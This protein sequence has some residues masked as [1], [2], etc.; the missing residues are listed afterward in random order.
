MLEGVRR[1]LGRM[2]AIESR[3]DGFRRLGNRE[4]SITSSNFRENLIK[5]SDEL[6]SREKAQMSVTSEN[7][8]ALTSDLSA[9]QSSL[10]AASALS[11]R[12][13]SL[14]PQI[15]ESSLVSGTLASV[16]EDSGDPAAESEEE[17]VGLSAQAL[18][19]MA[20]PRLA[21]MEPQGGLS[22]DKIRAMAGKYASEKGL[23]PELVMSVIEAESSYRPNEVSGAGAMGLMQLMPG[24]AE[25][26]GV[27]DAF[28]PEENIKGGTEYLSRMMKRFG[29][30]ELALA[31]YN[32]GP[33]NVD[34][35]DGVP[36]FD[37][38]RRYIQKVMKN[39]QKLSDSGK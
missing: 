29:S 33:G 23:D 24:T 3:I 31:A 34:R 6:E 14:L 12:A 19:K 9:G 30:T 32:A 36:P 27:R 10:P 20:S 39:Y 25:M 11:G 2:Q 7:S 21:S 28:D 5:A 17:N 13:L 26:L 16:S 15:M 18:G 35:Y 22:I 4:S 8:S 38:T 37:E 1:V